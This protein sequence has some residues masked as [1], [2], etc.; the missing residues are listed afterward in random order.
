MDYSCNAL[1]ALKD[2]C[3]LSIETM[4]Y[5]GFKTQR[6]EQESSCEEKY[7]IQLHREAKLRFTKSDRK[8]KC[9]VI[10]NNLLH[11]KDRDCN[12]NDVRMFYFEQGQ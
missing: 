6:A 2:G 9:I 5:V 10:E 4:K 3:L 1:F 8:N 12:P 7:K 11:Y